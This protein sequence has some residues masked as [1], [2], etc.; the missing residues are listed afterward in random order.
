MVVLPPLPSA[1]AG[2]ASPR[3]GPTSPSGAWTRFVY[4]ALSA[5]LTLHAGA[6]PSG[7]YPLCRLTITTPEGSA[8]FTGPD[9]HPDS[10]PVLPCRAGYSYSVSSSCLTPNAGQSDP[11][12]VVGVERYYSIRHGG[13][14]YDAPV[15]VAV[16]SKDWPANSGLGETRTYG[17]YTAADYLSQSSTGN[18]PYLRETIILGC[19]DKYSGAR[20]AILASADVY[21][22][23]PAV[24]SIPSLTSVST[25]VQFTNVVTNQALNGSNPSGDPPVIQAALSGLYPGGT[26]FLR[27]YPGKQA[28]DPADVTVIPNT[29]ATAPLGDLSARTLL[30]PIGPY[31]NQPGFYTIE[32]IQ[33]I[34]AYGTDPVLQNTATFNAGLGFTIHAG[35]G[36]VVH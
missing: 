33:Q 20:T 19:Y 26:S 18:A 29:T 25:Q 13:N 4:L 27:I 10:S 22:F 32:A 8:T 12:T 9:H 34:P 31:L 35:I 17:P 16:D 21:V 1:R 5:G 2:S 11:Q 15:Q 6:F 24:P 14:L 3:R 23:P 7:T 30:I 36:T 28:S